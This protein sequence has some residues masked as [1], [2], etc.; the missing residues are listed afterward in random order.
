[1]QSISC[2]VSGWMKHKL[3]SRLL[4][5]ELAPGEKHSDVTVFVGNDSSVVY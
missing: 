5:L 3:K 1:M 4:G 2:E